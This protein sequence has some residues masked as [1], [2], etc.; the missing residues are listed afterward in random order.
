MCP[1]FNEILPKKCPSF[2]EILLKKCPFFN[3]LYVEKGSGIGHTIL[4]MVIAY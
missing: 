4:L 3:V 2:N 1:S